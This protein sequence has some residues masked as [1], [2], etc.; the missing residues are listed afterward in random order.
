MRNIKH[1]LSNRQKLELVFQL[2]YDM[3]GEDAHE[4]WSAMHHRTRCHSH[5]FPVDF[6]ESIKY[7]RLDTAPY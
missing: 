1:T 3:V 5:E 7:A 6:S 2:D 4:Y